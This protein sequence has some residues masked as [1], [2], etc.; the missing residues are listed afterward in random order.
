MVIFLLI[1]IYQLKKLLKCNKDKNLF[2]YEDYFEIFK[3]I[4]KHFREN[5]KLILMEY[6]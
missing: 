3:I 2:L 1:N 5:E 6:N 4:Q